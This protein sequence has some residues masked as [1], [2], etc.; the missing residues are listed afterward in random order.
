VLRQRCS[1]PERDS[2]PVARCARVAAA[3]LAVL[4]VR[5]LLSDSGHATRVHIGTPW[6]LMAAALGAGVL[7]REAGR[8]LAPQLPRPRW[9]MSFV[10]A[11]AGSSGLLL[12]VLLAS[13]GSPDSGASVAIAVCV[14]LVLAASLHGARRL[15]SALRRD[16][17][18]IPPRRRRSTVPSFSG[19]TVPAPA[20][21]PLLAGWSDRGPPPRLS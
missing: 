1:E 20:P 21:A 12:T 9:S 8:G 19:Q 7:L 4:A 14:G 6:I 16:Q 10:T 5:V 3:L 13:G 2:G 17:G 15:L 18:R 11:W